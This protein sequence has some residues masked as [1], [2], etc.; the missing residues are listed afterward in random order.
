MLPGSVP[1]VFERRPNSGVK[2]SNRRKAVYTEAPVQVYIK[3]DPGLNQIFD[4]SLIKVEKNT[5][6]NR[7]S[8]INNRVK[9][10]WLN[11]A[12][13]VYKLK[14]MLTLSGRGGLEV[15]CTTMFKHS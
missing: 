11:L 15:E 5:M 14:C 9:Y 8:L 6:V 4:V 7:L 1:S 2:T 3:A 10:D 13:N 12:L